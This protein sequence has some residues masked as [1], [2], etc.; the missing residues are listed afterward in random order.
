LQCQKYKRK[1]YSFIVSNTYFRFKQFTVQQSGA[2]MK[3]NTDGVLL[4]AW[5]PVERSERAVDVGAG[6]GVIALML[7][8]RNA[9]LSID[10][11]EIDEASAQQAAAN[12]RQSP[13]DARIRVVHVSFQQFA[14]AAESRYHLIV[15]NPPYFVNALPSVDEKRRVSRHAAALPYAGLLN[16]AAALLEP[17]G[18]LSVILPCVEGALFTAQAVAR[19]LYCIRKTTVYAAAGK[20]AKRVLLLFAREPAPLQEDALAIHLPHGAGYTSEYKALTGDFYL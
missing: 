7:A 2:A 9:R 19:G 12:V 1:P 5:T 10:A 13:W 3:V 20:P 11:V 4:G 16:G 17:E 8:Q 15:S 18:L 6:T 14:Q